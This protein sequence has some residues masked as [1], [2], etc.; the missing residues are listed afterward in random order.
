MYRTRRDFSNG[1]SVKRIPT[2]RE[3][4]FP[5]KRNRFDSASDSFEP[6]FNRSDENA[7]PVLL[8]FKKFLATQDE[9]I[10]DDEAIAKYME[11]KLDFK[12]QELDK[13]FQQ[14]KSEEW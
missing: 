13:Y 4:E 3:D 8:T 5:A 11:Y 14:H 1:G 2:R 9:S 12:K 6:Q 10:T 7:S